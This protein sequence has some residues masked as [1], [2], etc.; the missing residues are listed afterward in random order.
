MELVAS[1]RL[2]RAQE[3]ID[4]RDD[5]HLGGRHEL[6]SLSR[7]PPFRPR[8][9]ERRRHEGGGVL[10][11]DSRHS[12]SEPRLHEN[13]VPVPPIE[14]LDAHQLV[15]HSHR[16]EEGRRDRRQAAAIAGGGDTDDRVGAASHLQRASDYLRICGEGALPVAVAQHHHR[17]TAARDVVLG[18]Y[19]PAK[20][21]LDAKQCERAPR[22]G[23]AQDGGHRAPAI[24]LRESKRRRGDPAED[25]RRAPPQVLDVRVGH[26]IEIPGVLGFVDVDER[27][28][29]DQR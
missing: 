25:A 7:S 28:G 11:L 4:S 26:R 27:V 5:L 20:L 22:H 2:R 13:A 23:F 16:N 9:V 21:R 14:H 3:R 19:G 17:V 6:E 10:G 12:G 18:L 24:D 1:A 29:I 15:L 8:R